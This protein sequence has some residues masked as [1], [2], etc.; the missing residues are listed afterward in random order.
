M[1]SEEPQFSM[2]SDIKIRFQYSLCFVLDF[3]KGKR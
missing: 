2:V 1:A 3:L